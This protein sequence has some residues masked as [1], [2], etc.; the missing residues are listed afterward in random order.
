MSGS[1]ADHP[2]EKLLELMGTLRGPEGCP[3]DREQTCESLKPMLIEEAFEVLEA[4]DQNDPHQLCEE[5]GDLLFQVVFHSQIAKEKGEFD[6]LQVCERLHDKMVGRHPH[7]FGSESFKDSQELLRNWERLKELEKKAS[8]RESSPKRSLLDGVPPKLPALYR[9]NQITSK[10]ARVGF[11]W[12][13]VE[14]IIKKL[15]E[16]VDELNRARSE[17]SDHQVKEELGDLL[18]T[19][20]NLC[21]RLE[22]DPET[23]LNQANR[24]FS[25]RFRNMEVHF[26][27]RGRKLG[28][29]GFDEMESCWKYVKMSEAS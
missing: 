19:V 25:R 22:V 9:A 27:K 5:L 15:L 12:P 4:L 14:G 29:V 3:W 20:V 28:D 13:T 7:V 2:F 1:D 18:F 21:R 10:A 24:K 23:S 8:G 16:E 6:A 11:D 26:G 17:G